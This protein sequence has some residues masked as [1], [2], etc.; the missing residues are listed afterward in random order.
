M[1]LLKRVLLLLLIPSLL[2][3]DIMVACHLRA[4]CEDPLCGVLPS[5]EDASCCESHHHCCEKSGAQLDSPSRFDDESVS[6]ERGKQGHD[7]GACAICRGA[8]I[9]DNGGDVELDESLIDHQLSVPADQSTPTVY[10]SLS[11]SHFL[12]RGPPGV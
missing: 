6:A 3:S 5:S 7:G 10:V 8:R 11:P 9:V 4:C 2:G 1:N 12:V